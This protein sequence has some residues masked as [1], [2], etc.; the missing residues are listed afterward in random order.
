MN[1]VPSKRV[2][3]TGDTGGFL[4]PKISTPSANAPFAYGVNGVQQSLGVL[5]LQ[6]LGGSPTSN[7]SSHTGAIAGQIPIFL[8]Q[9]FR[10]LP[11]V[12]LQSIDGLLVREYSL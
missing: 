7:P 8:S 3:S 4:Q 6:I 10:V 5:P 9:I 12:H 2:I 1:M 11:A